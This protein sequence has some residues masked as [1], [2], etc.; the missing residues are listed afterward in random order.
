MSPRISTVITITGCVA[1]LASPSASF[2]PSSP[3]RTAAAMPLHMSSTAEDPYP[4][5]LRSASACAGSE[6]CSVEDAEAYLLEVVAMQSGCAAGTLSGNG[7]CEDVLEVSAIVAD[8]RQKVAPILRQKVA[9]GKEG[10]KREVRSFWDQRQEELV[11]LASSVEGSGAGAL[12]APVKPVYLAM[13]ALYTVCLASSLNPADVDVDSLAGGVAPFT[14]EEFWWAV[15]DG[16]V[17]DLADHFFH[18]GGL[19]VGEVSATTPTL[20]HLTAQEV[21]WSVRDGYVADALSTGE[22]FAEGSVPFT[23]QEVWWSVQNGYST[24]MLEHYIRNSGLAV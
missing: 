16:Y 11:V 4:A 19:L 18:H 10:V 13:A 12:K 23:P 3:Q 17:R 1:L 7:V 15:R 6:S 9:D 22:G 21:A 20:D 24:D 5:L 8:L 14:A 2:V